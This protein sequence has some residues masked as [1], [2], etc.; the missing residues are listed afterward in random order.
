ML[1]R[2]LSRYMG[3]QAKAAGVKFVTAVDVSD[4]DLDNKEILV[5]GFESIRAE[6]IILATGSSPKILGIK[7]ELEYKGQ[8]ISCCAACDARYYKGKEVIVIG[9]G[10]SAIEE[11]RFITSFASKVKVIHQFAE[12]Q[13]SRQ[14]QAKAFANKKIDFI[15]EHEPREFIKGDGFMEVVI[16]DL[17]SGEFSTLRADGIFIFAGMRPNL[18]FIENTLK[19]DQWGYLE[20]DERMHTNLPDI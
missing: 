8:G 19:R 9:G 11:S 5:D 10:D 20:T 4:V 6:K 15:F 17:K 18:D 14:A 3:E 13:V 1:F 16:E 12:L 7:G 2:S